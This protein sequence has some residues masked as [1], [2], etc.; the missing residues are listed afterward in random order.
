MNKA[1]EC[2]TIGGALSFNHRSNS[3]CRLLESRRDGGFGNATFLF[4]GC[5]AGVELE[6]WFSNALVEECLQ[7]SD[8]VSSSPDEWRCHVDHG[9]HGGITGAAGGRVDLPNGGSSLAVEQR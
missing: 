3:S 6:N 4:T 2:W 8:D 5:K 9:I 7:S 1:F